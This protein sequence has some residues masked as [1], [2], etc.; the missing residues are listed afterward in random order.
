[1]PHGVQCI[2]LRIARLDDGHNGHRGARRLAS[3]EGL[4]APHPPQPLCLE[5][6]V[7]RKECG[8]RRTLNIPSDEGI[9]TNSTSAQDRCRL[10]SQLSSSLG[11]SSIASCDAS[12]ARCI[13]NC[14]FCMP[15]WPRAVAEPCWMLVYLRQPTGAKHAGTA[16]A[17]LAC[18]EAAA[19]QREDH[20]SVLQI[21]MGAPTA[22]GHYRLPPDGQLRSWEGIPHFGPPAARGSPSPGKAEQSSKRACTRQSRIGLFFANFFS[23]QFSHRLSS[24][25]WDAAFQATERERE[26]ERLVRPCRGLHAANNGSARRLSNTAGQSCLVIHRLHSLPAAEGALMSS[27]TGSEL[28]PASYPPRAKMERSASS[29][30]VGAKRGCVAD[31]A[32]P[33]MALRSVRPA[34]DPFLADRCTGSDALCATGALRSHGARLMGEKKRTRADLRVQFSTSASACSL[35]KLHSIFEGFFVGRRSGDARSL[36]RSSVALQA[37]IAEGSSPSFQTLARPPHCAR[38]QCTLVLAFQPPLA[39]LHARVTSEKQA[40]ACPRKASWP[41]E[42]HAVSEARSHSHETSHQRFIVSSREFARQDRAA[43]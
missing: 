13:C 16:R 43:C 19:V 41:T 11:L 29:G 9:F 15:S 31:A 25:M 12:A 24:G 2:G 32:Q 37:R 39:I 35:A 7:D 3:P 34:V 38:L 27:G 20:L 42:S 6:A 17:N 21:G 5:Q 10:P 1:L 4:F 30:R 33:L 18:R 8:R 23:R 22:G 26:R 40:S 36:A 14:I 28:L